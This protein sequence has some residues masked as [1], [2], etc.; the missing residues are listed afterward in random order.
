MKTRWSYALLTAAVL[1]AAVFTLGGTAR[2]AEAP[3]L[4]ELKGAEKARVAKLIEG[5]RKEGNFSWAT[6]L[7]PV[8]AAKAMEKAFKKLYGLPKVKF[9][10][11]NR[12]SGTLIKRFEQEIKADKLSV[13]VVVLAAASWLHSMKRR[14]HLMKYVSPEDKH[15]DLAE[16]ANM[17]GGGYWV[18]DGQI[19]TMAV[20]RDLAGNVK[21]TSWYDLLKPEFKGKVLVGDARPSETYTLWYKGLRERLPKSYF[22]KLSAAGAGVMARGSA[23]RRSLMA[24]E[25]WLGTTIMARHNWIAKKAGVNMDPIYPKEGVVALPIGSVIMAK[26]KNPNMAK[27]FVDYWRSVRG[28]HMLLNYN[29]LNS[30]RPLPPHKDEKINKLILAKD[31]IAPPI[32]KINVIPTDWSK[33]TPADVKK[34]KAEFI[35][36][37]GSGTKK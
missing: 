37:F 19:N 28:H 33:V 4:K 20:N 21:L 13:D 23:Q 5:A 12:R 27:L 7:A 16:K 24:G 32:D 3:I 15:Y 6:N 31:G 26:A 34:W 36:V 1:L 29:P 10:F 25:Y 17:N 2:A 11:A 8:K 9:R 30:G 18:S 14:G 22:Q 35:E